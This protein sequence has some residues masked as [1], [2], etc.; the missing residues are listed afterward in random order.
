MENFL[1]CHPKIGRVYT[2]KI[3]TEEQRFTAKK[4]A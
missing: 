3:A 1:F 2:K 4:E